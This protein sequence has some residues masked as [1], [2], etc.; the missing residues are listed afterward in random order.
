MSLR[1]A[2]N[3]AE[4]ILHGIEREIVIM[5]LIEHPNIMRLYDVW[6]TSTEL[7]LILEYVEGG[8]LFEYLCNK[9][10]LSTTE[11][12]GYFQ[13][14]MT[15]VDYC[16][17]F[18]IAHRD[19]KPENLLLD[20]NKNI[21]VADFGMAAWQGKSDMLQTACGSPH[22][23]AP[24]VIMGSAYN[25]ACS[26]VWSCG[27]ILYALLAGRLPFDDEDLG[28]LLEKVKIG[29]FTMPKDIDP[30]A[31]NLIRRML[32]KDIPK[33]ITVPE[34][35]K[36]PFYLS[37]APKAMPC[38]VPGLDDI[39]R[40][41]PS[42]DDIDLDILSNLRTL[43][44]GVPDEQLIQNLT[45]KRQAWE[46][47]VYH[48]LVRYRAKHLDNYE[49]EEE[50]RMVEK[51]RAK[52]ARSKRKKNQ[53]VRIADEDIPP[54]AGPPTP[55]RARRN[56]P[57][58][59]PS[60]SEGPSRLRQITAIGS[61]LFTAD[62]GAPSENAPTPLGTQ[63]ANQ[64]LPATLPEHPQDE[65]IQQFF[66]QIVEHLN[67]MQLGKQHPPTPTPVVTERAPP[68]SPLTLDL[69]SPFKVRGQ[70]QFTAIMDH[71]AARS[72]ADLATRPLS[73]RRREREEG[74]KEN[75]YAENSYLTP[76]DGP[77][78]KSSV[79]SNVSTDSN[80][81]RERHVQL[82]EPTLHGHGAKL[83]KKRSVMRGAS[84]SLSAFSGVS[85]A[86]SFFLSSTP[87]RRWFGNIFRFGPTAYTLYSTQDAYATRNECR[88]ILENMG[89]A[90][91]LLQAEGMGTLKCRLEELRDP[92]GIMATVKAV[93]FRIELRIPQT[94]QA[95]AG[96]T[97]AMN[98]VMEKGAASSFKLVYTRLRR[99]WDLDMPP[100]VH[101]MD[102][103]AL[104]VF[105]SERF[106]EVTRVT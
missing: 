71:V 104:E 54:R 25:G 1:N 57:S 50:E 47:G 28:I 27:V 4:R 97:V 32:E 35:L 51:R 8:E 5:K 56:E 41:L 103:R 58:V 82:L 100:I 34:I 24:E 33:R 12:L 45:N 76:D 23:A 31:Q 69:G 43:W 98:I 26:D 90:V 3:E 53:R 66:H 92:V 14:I 44:P 6:E 89:V 83:Q 65:R 96:Y 87:K 95:I 39:A 73:I 49:E 80:S 81:R 9:G 17:R 22:Y 78:R 30:E 40:P 11:A 61:G 77:G 42:K 72:R 75:S 59:T 85:E 67:I 99:E 2:E 13:Q 91:M 19:L 93:K 55:N 101:T 79:R 86:G 29:K 68:P 20:G 10:R 38:D 18:N 36:H 63:N 7:F 64:A 16:H 106:V 105:A 70:D 74:D 52:R 102:S 21:K 46:K 94:V 62:R 88:R 48:L 60:P 84:P 37:Q 15:A